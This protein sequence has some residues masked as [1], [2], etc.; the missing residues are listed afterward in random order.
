MIFKLL[1]ILFAAYF[2]KTNEVFSQS[3]FGKYSYKNQFFY[4]SLEL[5]PSGTFVY[6]IKSESTG[7]E[8]KGNW[9]IRGR[10]LILDSAP[11]RDGI[12]CHESRK[13]RKAFNYFDVKSKSDKSSIFYHLYVIKYA[14]D[15]VELSNQFGI[16]RIRSKS[17]KGFFIKNA[18]GIKSPTYLTQFR[19]MNWFDILFE[20]ERVF[21]NENW[22][23]SEIGIL[24]RGNGGEYEN[25]LLR[26]E[27]PESIQF[28]LKPIATAC[29]FGDYYIRKSP[30]IQVLTQDQLI[31]EYPKFNDFYLNIYLPTWNEK[32]K[33]SI[34]LVINF[35]EDRC[36]VIDVN[37]AFM[38]H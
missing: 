16:S 4:E 8:C 19:S 36:N 12:I 10:N 23:I 37:D 13:R 28:N 38:I 33:S 9:Q 6:C 5:L 24:P 14:G 1:T 25:F 20:T 34:F 29:V 15:T 21:D 3:M 11:Q 26:K 27:N 22:R 35:K 7:I 32:M 17:I 18:S 31:K 2:F 30:V